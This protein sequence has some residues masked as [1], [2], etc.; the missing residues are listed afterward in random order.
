MKRVT[1]G[2]VLGRREQQF[3][4]FPALRL[5]AREAI[6]LFGRG[7]P[8]VHGA[9]EFPHEDRLV[10]LI[11]ELR[12]LLPHLLAALE[13]VHVDQHQHRAV[14]PVVERAIGPYPQ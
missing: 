12:L 9:V 4:R 3:V 14:D 13:R 1:I 8:V 10:H 6:C 5:L 2:L 11:Q 7:V